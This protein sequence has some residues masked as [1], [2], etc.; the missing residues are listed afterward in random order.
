M[1]RHRSFT[2]EEA[3]HELALDSDSD[4]EPS[5]SEGDEDYVPDGSENDD[6]VETVQPSTSTGGFTNHVLFTKLTPFPIWPPSCYYGNHRSVL[7]NVKNNICS[8]AVEKIR[9]IGKEI[10]K[11]QPFEEEY[12][13]FTLCG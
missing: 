9:K 1:S 3:L 2:A 13:L 11:L 10:K 5:D 12:P 8:I 4:R 7:C 6:D